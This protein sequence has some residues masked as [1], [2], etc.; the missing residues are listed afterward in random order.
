MK[1]KKIS[2][3]FKERKIGR[4]CTEEENLVLSSKK[5]LK[6]EERKKEIKDK[7]SLMIQKY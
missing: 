2:R 6:G 7:D 4:V 5:E 3:E 1:A